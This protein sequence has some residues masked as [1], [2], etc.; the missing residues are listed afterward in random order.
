MRQIVML[1]ALLVLPLMSAL[2]GC[3]ITV[4]KSV[5][6]AG[7]EKCSTSAGPAAV[8]TLMVAGLAAFAVYASYEMEDTDHIAIPVAIG[9]GLIYAI[10][11]GVGYTRAAGCKREKSKNGLPY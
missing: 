11:A 2:G 5:A 4:T 1:R 7:A 8:D 6:S 3:A 9:T 10:S